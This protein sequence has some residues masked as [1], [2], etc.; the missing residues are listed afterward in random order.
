MKNPIVPNGDLTD[1]EWLKRE[2][3]FHE[4]VNFWLIGE[5]SFPPNICFSFIDN[6]AWKM[7]E[8]GKI[9]TGK[10]TIRKLFTQCKDLFLQNVL[11][12]LACDSLLENTIFPYVLVH[13]HQRVNLSKI[14]YHD[15]WLYQSIVKKLR[16]LEEQFKKVLGIKLWM[17]H[18]L[19][20]SNHL[21][22]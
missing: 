17:K 3:N 16:Q 1:K 15:K 20:E 9:L 10:I 13:S 21:F 19:R 8:C 5:L 11:R 14:S 4:F 12:I 7:S 18:L 2:I 6:T 22:K